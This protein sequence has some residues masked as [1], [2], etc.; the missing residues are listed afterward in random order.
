[1]ETNPYA[2]IEC[3]RF[4]ATLVQLDADMAAPANA[5]A[6]RRLEMAMVALAKEN[7]SIQNCLEFV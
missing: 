7:L 4:K 1:M 6:W 3:V 5:A 2:L